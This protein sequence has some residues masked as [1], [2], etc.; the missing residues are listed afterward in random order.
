MLN[1]L[2]P[3]IFIKDYFRE[4]QKLLEVKKDTINKILLVKKIL[5]DCKKKKNK[6]IIFGNGGSSS[7]ASHFSVDITKN[8]GIRSITFNEVNL[9]TCFAND[10]GYKNWI[11]KSIDYYAKRNDV[12]IAISSS[13][14]SENI[15]N[16]CKMA[17]KIGIKNIITLTGFNKN[18]KVSKLGRVNFWINSKIY[19]YVENMHQIILLCIIDLIISSRQQ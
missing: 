5:L 11:S 12:V 15:I 10:F 13:G 4:F 3:S 7:I 6:I 16:G 19:N 18:N 1:N 14:K 2:D 9:I 8:A 17:K